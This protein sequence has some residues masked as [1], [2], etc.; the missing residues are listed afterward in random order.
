MNVIYF[1]IFIGLLESENALGLLRLRH[2]VRA[3]ER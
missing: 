3:I 1:A 2:R